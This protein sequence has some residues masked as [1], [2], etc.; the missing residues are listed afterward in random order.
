MKLD[1]QWAD[2]RQA[3]KAQSKERLINLILALGA[4]SE[5][6][7]QQIRIYVSTAGGDEELL[8]C[9][10]LIRSYIDAHAER[11]GFV[12]YRAACNAVTDASQVTRRAEQAADEGERSMPG[13]ISAS[14]QWRFF[15]L[16]SGEAK[17][18][19]RRMGTRVSTGN[20][21]T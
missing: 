2:L 1:E 18:P 21:G 19:D 13:W 6:A 15:L 16:S 3:L 12:S 11:D 7:E 14:A 20:S 4:D 9:R 8:E 17:L 10:A 5:L